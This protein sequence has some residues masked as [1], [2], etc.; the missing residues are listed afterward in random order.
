VFETWAQVD[1]D[2]L[3]AG[4]S[5]IVGDHCDLL[6][7]ARQEEQPEPYT[8][9]AFAGYLVADRVLA[10]HQRQTSHRSRLEQLVRRIR[11]RGAR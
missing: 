10:V 6:T 8:Y 11:Q 3:L 1:A 7:P 9:A 5:D 4:G 2:A